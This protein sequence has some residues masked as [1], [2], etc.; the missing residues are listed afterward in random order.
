[1][2]MLT[3]IQTY[4][5]HAFASIVHHSDRLTELHHRSSQPQTPEAKAEAARMRDIAVKA[6]VESLVS[7]NTR[8]RDQCE[9]AVRDY[10]T[11]HNSFDEDIQSD[12]VTFPLFDPLSRCRV[13]IPARSANCQHLQ[14]FDLNTF[15]EFRLEE[16]NDVGSAPC[17][18]C[19]SRVHLKSV[20]VD[21]LCEAILA[22][23]PK[24]ALLDDGYVS[25]CLVD[26]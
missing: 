7:T 3:G 22:S 10:F 26:V 24:V 21:A 13:E 16:L 25:C 6:M 5:C 14:F 1:M 11:I 19:G 12:S 17:P 2:M 4:E 18:I 9:Q 23:A 8:P 15:V 20:V